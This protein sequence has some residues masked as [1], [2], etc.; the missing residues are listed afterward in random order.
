M[1]SRMA[2]RR[3]A[4]GSSRR[5]F[6]LIEL[7]A[8]AGITAL[9]AGFIVAIVSNLSGFWNR[10]SGRLSTE[11]QARYALDQLTLDLSAAQFRDDGN[12]WLAA[13]VVN[14]ANGNS[15]TLWQIA[16]SNPKPVGGI[17]LALT[18]SKIS[19]ARFGNAGV[20]LRF[21]TTS[22]GSN[23]A[24]SAATISAP[25]AVGYRIIRRF[26]APSPTNTKTAYLLHRAEVRPARV[27]TTPIQTTGPGVLES[28]YSITAAAYTTTGTTTRGDPRTVQVPGARGDLSAV[29]ADNVIDFGVRCYVRDATTPTGL[30]L[31]FP[32]SDDR[33]TPAT[34]NN[35]LQSKLPSSTPTTAPEFAH[36]ALSPDVV[37]VMVRILTDEG[38]RLIASY[39][40]ANSPLTVPPGVNAQQYWWQL[41]AANSQVY[42]RRIVL[43]AKPL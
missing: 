1:S 28:G 18:A 30:R 33:G 25:V 5:A 19:D 7:L 37:E 38:A 42:T 34:T 16:A 15:P 21:F 41:A 9:L 10:T 22:R 35:P 20:W 36:G 40:Q 13:D 8:A 43:N 23:V 29:I 12:V 27:T 31:I 2:I 26:S 24:A 11:A 4:P 3:S 6:A 14:S 32:A 39:E 17:S